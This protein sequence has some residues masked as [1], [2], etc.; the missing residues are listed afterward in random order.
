MFC[1]SGGFFNIKVEEQN[2]QVFSWRGFVCNLV[3][4][5]KH[6]MVAI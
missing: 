6:R 5:K 4:E 3:R 2:L 1:R